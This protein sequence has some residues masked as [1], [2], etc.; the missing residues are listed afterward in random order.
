MGII[1]FDTETTGL[2]KPDAN[3]LNKQP[4]ITEFFGVKYVE[5]IDFQQMNKLHLMIKPPVPLSAEIT[6][7][8]GITNDYLKDCPSFAEVYDQLVDF[9][10]GSEVMVAH[11]VAFD[12]SMLANELLRIDKVLNFPWSPE[13]ICT[14]EKSMYL[15]QR[16]L[17]LTRLHEYATGQSEIPGA[18]RAGTD[19]KALTV[20]YQ[21]LDNQG[22][23]YD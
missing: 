7:I 19:V 8:T 21:W 22:K 10:M 5:G 3:D 17:N 20:C 6:R 4:Y 9:F 18:H 12:R 11:N 16:R 23:I 2:I 14:V 13:H 1:I 15:E